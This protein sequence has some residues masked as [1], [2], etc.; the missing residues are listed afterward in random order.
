MKMGPSFSDFIGAWQIEREIVDARARRVA[1]LN[2]RAVFRLNVDGTLLY[3]EAGQLQIADQTPVEATRQYIW[4]VADG[5]IDVRFEDGAAFH[6]IDLGVMMPDATH[7]CDP[8]LYN[9]SYDF[10]TWPEWSASWRVVGPAKDYRMVT[11]YRR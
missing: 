9:V 3:S 1:R 8:D 2:G 11:Q 7:H 10:R 4:A 6:Q 5:K